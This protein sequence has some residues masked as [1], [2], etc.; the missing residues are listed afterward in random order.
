MSGETDQDVS[1]WTVDTLRDN[2]QRQIDNLIRL[3]D[4]RYQTQTKALDAAFVAAQTATSTARGEDQRNL[5]TALSSAE[6]AVSKAEIAT[7]KRFDGVNEFRQAFADL[8][9]EQMPRAEAD[10]RLMALSEKIEE[11]RASVNQGAGRSAVLGSML[12]YLI[13]IASIVVAVV[14]IATR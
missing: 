1:G 2:I 4:E 6:K 11:L 10:A 14:A 12:G 5:A 13:A 8:V 7:E 9:R 3:L